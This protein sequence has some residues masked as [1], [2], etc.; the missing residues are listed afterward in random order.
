MNS[1]FALLALSPLFAP[2]NDNAVIDLC[3]A[4]DEASATRGDLC[5]VC[6][7]DVYAHCDDADE[8]PY[9]A[10]DIEAA[11]YFPGKM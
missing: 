10:G 5:R 9:D 2:A 7:E 3:L 8:F 1:L 4:C 6:D 11:R